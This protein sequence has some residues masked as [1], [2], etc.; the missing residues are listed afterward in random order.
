[1]DARMM[2]SKV[3]QSGRNDQRIALDDG[4]QRLTYRDLH[5]RVLCMADWLGAQGVRVVALHG[6]N[7]I[8]WVVADLAAQVAGCVLV[9]LPPFFSDD[10]ILHCV[11]DA[12][13]DLLLLA[14]AEKQ[15]VVLTNGFELAERCP[16]PCL[17]AFRRE[18]CSST[19]PE[20]TQKITYTSG[21]TGAPKGVCLSLEQQ[22][23]VAESLVER[24]GLAEPR[25]F[26][27][28]PLS[29]LLENIAG[30]YAPLLAGG[31]V[32]LAGAAQRGLSGSSGLDTQCLLD[33][34]HQRQPT[35][36]ILLPQILGA[37]V[38]AG[39][40]GH[41]A[42]MSL[43]FVAVG[44][45][46]VSGELINQ[47]RQL[48]WPVVQG[49]GLSECGSVV[50]LAT[51]DDDPESCGEPLPHLELAFDQGELV[52]KGASFL[53]YLAD[54]ESWYP[55]QVHTGDLVT[56]RNGL[57]NVTGRC[58]HVLI[59]GFGR[60]ISPEWV[61]KALTR[62][63]LFS[64]CV[65]G[66]NDRDTLYALISAPAQISDEQI[67]EHIAGVNAT[68]PDYARIGHWQRLEP[69]QWAP[70]MTANGKIRRLQ[71]DR[72][73]ADEIASMYTFQSNLMTDDS[74]VHDPIYSGVSL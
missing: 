18:A 30:V 69:Q 10:Q 60:N 22:W 34:L 73:F 27:L 21:S 70:V 51:L 45:A 44:G 25:H 58:K 55:P 54:P 2:L 9:P 1:M 48:G 74:S 32:C 61:E 65:V 62:R 59:T 12:G 37:L 50:A 41:R 35:S 8:D 68:L 13:V 71:I 28:L 66:G 49:Y 20:G 40:T 6:D 57:V 14:H 24:V 38:A 4:H 17:R 46:P 52:V 7:S 16:L 63:P 47:G 43:E 3:F 53:G 26:C 29:T 72:H 19:R 31:R 36:L 33:C 42:P 15:S 11:E 5:I 64:Q 56:L 67:T 39:S 23:R